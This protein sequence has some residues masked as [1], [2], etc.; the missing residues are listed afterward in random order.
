MAVP[1]SIC[2]GSESSDDE[3]G[4]PTFQDQTVTISQDG[5]FESFDTFLDLIAAERLSKMPRSG[6]QWDRVLKHAEVFANQIVLVHRML[7][8]WQPQSETEL[9]SFWANCRLLLE[10]RPYRSPYHIACL[11]TT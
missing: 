3:I 10:V 5:G 9:A 1:K 4:L 2:T 11:L 6:S 7:E 8:D